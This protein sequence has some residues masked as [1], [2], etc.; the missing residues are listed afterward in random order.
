MF[1]VTPE[2][3][4]WIAQRLTAM[5][6]HAAVAGLTVTALG[7]GHGVAT[8][9]PP[10]ARPTAQSA[11][12]S[13]PP[14]TPPPAPPPPTETAPPPAAPAAP[15]ATPTVGDGTTAVASLE[16][17]A[18]CPDHPGGHVVSAEHA[19]RLTPDER[20]LYH[21]IGGGTHAGNADIAAV[22]AAP[23][24]AGGGLGDIGQMQVSGGA[25]AVSPDGLDGIGGAS[26]REPPRPP[27][28]RHRRHRPPPAH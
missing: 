21:A 12:P 17:G 2:I 22:L 16:D 23:P 28:L 14:S 8:P 11:P 5:A 9:P 13:S 7:C 4:T 18:P 20:A 10:A 15:P 3:Q 26:R 6:R 19:R 25:R 24:A 27:P 1:A